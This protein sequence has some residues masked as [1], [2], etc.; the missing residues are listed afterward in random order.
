MRALLWSLAPMPAL[1]VAYLLAPPYVVGGLA[2]ASAFFVVLVVLRTAR[3]LR[4]QELHNRRFAS[5]VHN[6]TD[7]VTLIDADTTILFIS[8]SAERL[9]GF[10][11]A[12]LEGSSLRVLP[13]RSRFA[14]PTERGSTP[15]HCPPTCCTT[16]TSAASSSR[17]ATSRSARP[18]ST[19]SNTTPFT[20]RSPGSRIARSS[21]TASTTRSRM[22]SGRAPL[23]P[24]S[25]WM[26][27]TSRSSTT[28]TGTRRATRC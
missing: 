10:E 20:T 19:S 4:E 8:P 23:S 3:L 2:L 18:S 13:K 26:S 25:S 9:L 11:A 22:P 7:L 15:R 21:V 12:A 14:A 27:T 6:S 5:L 1:L 17:R 24:H 28:R 16:R